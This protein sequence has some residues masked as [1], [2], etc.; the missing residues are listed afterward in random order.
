MLL[1]MTALNTYAQEFKLFLTGGF[2]ASQINGDDLAGFDQFGLNAGAGVMRKTGRK[3]GLQFEI[4]YSQKG[5]RDTPSE[6]N[7]IQDTIIRVNYIDI[8]VLFNYNYNEKLTFQGGLF[9]GVLINAYFDNNDL[10][11]DKTKDYALMDYG[12]G[13]GA[14]YRFY[15]GFSANLRVTQSFISANKLEE[16]YNLVS[17]LTFRY[18]FQ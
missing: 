11:D 5:S 13:G 6:G 7:D 18:T 10:R 1:L 15:K 14:E 16:Y 8:P 12:F 17:S 4:N 3:T 2:N 9:A